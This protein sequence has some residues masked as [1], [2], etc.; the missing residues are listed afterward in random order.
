LEKFI[1]DTVLNRVDSISHDVFE[2]RFAGL[3]QLTNTQISTEIISIDKFTV[4]NNRDVY[5][6]LNY[7]C[8]QEFDIGIQ[9]IT[10][11]DILNIYKIT[12]NPKTEYNKIYI[13]FTNEVADP[14][15]V[16]FKIL[17]RVRKSESTN[18]AKIYLDNLKLV[19]FIK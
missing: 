17:F 18:P 15:S 13:D 19:H 2:D 11:S 14:L 6:E 4:D 3:I 7:K 9:I 16:S 12:V 5:L 1:G 8:N 10:T